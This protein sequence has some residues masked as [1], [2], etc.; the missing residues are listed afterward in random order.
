[1]P[2]G[3][4]RFCFTLF[5]YTDETIEWFD[6]T[7]IFKYVCYGREICPK[8]L[9]PHLQGYFEFENGNRKS[10]TA[11]IAYLLREGLVQHPHLTLC[12]GT[13]EQNIAYCSKQCTEDN[14]FW[15][16]GLRPL[17]QGHRSD[18]DVCT[19]MILNGDSIVQVATEHPSTFVRYHKGLMTFQSLIQSRRNW[20]TEVFWLWGPSGSGKSRWAWTT[21][22][23]AYQKQANTRWWCCYTGQDT[24]IIDD[25]RPSREM[26]F[27]FI[28]NLFDRYPLLLETKG[29]QVQCQL[30]TV[31]VTCPFSPDQLL[32]HLEW[33]GAE[34]GAQLK[35]RIEHVIEFPQ[36]ASFFL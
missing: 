28:L 32:S 16:K 13:A 18:I 11:C 25:F 9:K 8:T 24:C 6:K 22:P 15:E 17:G 20:K 2:G 26:P 33:V 36:M 23:D 30:K 19:D 27:N 7:E 34:Q 35:R 3:Y 21:Y 14:P 29:G 4:C 10:K 31:V 1:M 12:N 5:N